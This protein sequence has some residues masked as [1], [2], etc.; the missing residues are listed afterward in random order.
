MPSSCEMVPRLARIADLVCGHRHAFLEAWRTRSGSGNLL[1][2]SCRARAVIDEHFVTSWQCALGGFG[3]QYGLS[4]SEAAHCNEHCDH[5][6]RLHLCPLFA[7]L[8]TVAIE[9][10]G[11]PKLISHNRGDS[12]LH[13]E[14]R[15][16]PRSDTTSSIALLEISRAICENDG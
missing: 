11:P 6:H 7:C 2:L 15:V 16:C 9:I 13:L 5:V 4:A 3:F 12:L 8:V 10:G 14:E 1:D